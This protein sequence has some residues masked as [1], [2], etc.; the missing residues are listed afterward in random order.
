[1]TMMGKAEDTNLL[2]WAPNIDGKVAGIRNGI[3][4][5]PQLYK[6]Q[7]EQLLVDNGW[8]ATV[9][10]L[11]SETQHF[12]LLHVCEPSCQENWNN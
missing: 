2:M 4:Y 5:M 12:G 6:K 11:L 7:I 9:T 3:S 10:Y 1:M 8:L